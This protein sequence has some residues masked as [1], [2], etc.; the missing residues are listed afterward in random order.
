M[1]WGNANNNRLGT[2]SD[3]ISDDLERNVIAGRTDANRTPDND[4]D[5][6]KL[7]IV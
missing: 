1:I 2:N 6:A 4:C 5:S 7:V 3:G